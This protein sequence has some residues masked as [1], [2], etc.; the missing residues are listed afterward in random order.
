MNTYVTQIQKKTT[1]NNSTISIFWQCK[2]LEKLPNIFK[3]HS[4]VV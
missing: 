1:Y 4:A 3:G 2:N